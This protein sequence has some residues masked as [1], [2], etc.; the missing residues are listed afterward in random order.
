MVSN[1]V[2]RDGAE[3]GVG[4]VLG[5]TFKLRESSSL[6]VEE[7]D[8]HLL[9]Q[10]VGDFRRCA[11]VEAGIS[12]S[13]RL[14]TPID[15]KSQSRTKPGYELPPPRIVGGRSSQVLDEITIG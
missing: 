7:S 11:G 1:Q 12:L 8:E 3:V 13:F 10:I 15:G 6:A 14:K 2:D 4:R 9:G 5:P